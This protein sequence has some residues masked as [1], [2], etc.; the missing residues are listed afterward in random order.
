MTTTELARSVGIS[1]GKVSK[2]ET[3]AQSARVDHV[4]GWARACGVDDRTRVQLGTLARQP[5]LPPPTAEPLSEPA[6]GPR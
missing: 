3:G 6:F 2:I 4:D 5:A 1:Q